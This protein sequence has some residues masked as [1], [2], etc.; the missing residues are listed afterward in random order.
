MNRWQSLS[1]TGKIVLAGVVLLAGCGFCSFVGMLSDD[2]S[3][4]SVS[5]PAALE[6][7]D[8]GGGAEVEP[9]ERPRSTEKPSEP[10]A[11]RLPGLG[12]TV[13]LGTTRWKVDVAEDLGQ[14]V[15]SG[16]QFIDDLTTS[17]KFVRIGL[18]FANDDSDAA[19]VPE[20]AIVDG[21][22]RVFE[23]SSDAWMVIDSGVSCVLEQ[24]NPGMT[25]EC[26]WIYELPAD[27]SD[28]RL[29]VKSQQFF[30]DTTDIDLGL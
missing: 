8:D 1:R 7:P 2:T 22:D 12:D 15:P 30:A 27:A 16:N 9:T 13:S 17:G 4:V 3:Q 11:E 29:R 26:L 24:V 21:R 14:S 20:P 10:T 23:P 19:F 25:Q 28:L 18:I 6:A 5:Q